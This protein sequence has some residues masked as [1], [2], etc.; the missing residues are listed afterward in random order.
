M[1]AYEQTDDD[2]PKR[3]GRREF[4]RH[5][6]FGLFHECFRKMIERPEIRLN[7]ATT[8]TGRR[9]ERGEELVKL[10]DD[11]ESR[12]GGGRELADF[13]R[14]GAF[15]GEARF[16]VGGVLGD[17]RENGLL[18]VLR[19]EWV[20]SRE[21]DFALKEGGEDNEPSSWLS[22]VPTRPAVTQQLHPHSAV[23]SQLPPPVLLQ[24]SSPHPRQLVSSLAPS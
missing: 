22:I 23:Q 5:L 18:D 6:R 15:R 3:I 11:S 14:D 17:S 20:V 13:G 16:S 10:G 19:R 4:C 1:P 21:F 24:P 7:W 8:G 2:P 9:T 12:F